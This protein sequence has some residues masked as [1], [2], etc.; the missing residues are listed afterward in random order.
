MKSLYNV[1]MISQLTVNVI[2]KYIANRVIS[3]AY[4]WACWSE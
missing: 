3:E 2:K 1:L 4:D